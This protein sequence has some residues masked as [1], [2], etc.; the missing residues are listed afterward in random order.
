MK[1]TPSFMLDLGNLPT[2]VALLQSIVLSLATTNEKLLH[3][4]REANRRQFGRKAESV[5]EFQ[6][7][8]FEKLIQEQLAGIPKMAAF[9]VAPKAPSKG[10]GRRTPSSALPRHHEHYPLPE[11][12]KTCPDCHSKLKKFGTESR[13]VVEFVPASLFVRV[14]TSEKWGCPCC[15][16]KVVTSELPDLPV[17]KGMAGEGLLAH[18]VTAKFCDHL[19]LYRQALILRRHG[20]DVSRSTLCDWVAQAAEKLEPVYLA[21]KADVLE[22]KV[23]HSDDTTVPVLEGKERGD[24]TQKKKAKIARLWTWVGDKNHP[25]TVYSFSPDRKQEW[26]LGFASS[27]KGYLQADAYSGY[28][29]LYLRGIKEVACWAHAR[30]KIVEAMETAPETGQAALAFIHR[31]YEVEREAKEK[32]ANER[33]RLRQIHSKPVLDAFKTWLDT[34]ALMVLPKSVMGLAMGY[35]LRQWQALN[36]YLEDGDLAIDNNPA[37]RALKAVALGR[38]N[39]LFLGSNRGGDRAAVLYSIVESCKRHGIDPFEYIRDVIGK[40]GGVSTK[41]VKE[42]MPASWKATRL[43]HLKA[44]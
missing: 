32:P 16:D 13:N 10:H 42:L 24:R 20:F 33:K 26:P 25:H 40:I 9:E 4:L 35:I 28:H 41:K 29:P 36:R 18:V 6:M 34:Q 21:M 39:F 31:L 2:D 11:S 5:S 3:H 38:K 8:L 1:K 19:P 14:Q 23:I 22:S 43:E 7:V 37:E 17:E 44:A 15:L 30:R 27:W 12:Q